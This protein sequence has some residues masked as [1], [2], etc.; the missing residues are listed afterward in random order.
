M[1]SCFMLQPSILYKICF[2]AR[3]DQEACGFESRSFPDTYLRGEI[4]E[5]FQHLKQFINQVS[6][7]HRINLNAGNYGGT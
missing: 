3:R 6:Q 4:L 5:F 7:C 1:Y 2:L